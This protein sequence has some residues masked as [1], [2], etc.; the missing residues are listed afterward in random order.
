MPN[1]QANYRLKLESG[2]TY[3]M[4]AV[5]P[6]HQPQQGQSVAKAEAHVVN[7]TNTAVENVILI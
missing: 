6:R 3:R 2:T 5:N 4:Q 1:L 7:N